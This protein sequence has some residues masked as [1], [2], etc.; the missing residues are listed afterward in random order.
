MLPYVSF[1][2]QYIYS[3]MQIN[4]YNHAIN[5]ITQYTCPCNMLYTWK[6]DIQICNKEISLFPMQC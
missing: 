1:S 5:I 4:N 3:N 6:K 2:L